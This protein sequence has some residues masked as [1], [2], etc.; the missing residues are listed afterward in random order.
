MNKDRKRILGFGI[1]EKHG[2]SYAVKR[3][4][5]DVHWIPLGDTLEGGEDKIKTYC[6][7][8]GITFSD[9][10]SV[11]PAILLPAKQTE[12]ETKL[13]KLEETAGN[14]AKQ[15]SDLQD[16]IKRLLATNQDNVKKISELEIKL[17]EV[18]KIKEEVHQKLG[19]VRES[20]ETKKETKQVKTESKKP[21]KAEA[22]T[23]ILG[24]RL[25]LR[26][27]GKGK[28]R[29]VWYA[30]KRV[31]GKEVKVYLGESIEGAEEKIR[32]KEGI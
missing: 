21:D 22:Q 2:K 27:N 12:L 17:N 18:R 8:N 32:D 29:K 3:I 9:N 20:K 4:A 30:V 16:E 28:G 24:Y 1:Y 25:S 11:V 7:Q 15:I 14:Q 6:Q 5:K 31:S 19:I 13:G 10:V 26:D 23:E